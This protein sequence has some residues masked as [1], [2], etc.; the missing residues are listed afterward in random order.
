MSVPYGII[1]VQVSSLVAPRKHLTMNNLTPRQAHRLL[2]AML[3]GS[4]MYAVVPALRQAG[5][6][7]SLRDL[8]P[9]RTS[10]SSDAQEPLESGPGSQRRPKTVVPTIAAL[11]DSLNVAI[12]SLPATR[13]VHHAGAE[14]TV[15][16]FSFEGSVENCLSV[17]RSIEHQRGLGT[18]ATLSVARLKL[19]RPTRHVSRTEGLLFI[20]NR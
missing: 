13:T 14:L 2:V 12:Y 5:T 9:P 20:T 16:R 15:Q 18:F 1:L 8:G 19:T 17:C 6:L 7:Y 10:L 4:L 11:A 3:L